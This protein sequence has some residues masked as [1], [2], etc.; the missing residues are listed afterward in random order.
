MNNKL[1]EQ[2]VSVRVKL[3][4]LWTAFMFLYIYVDYFHLYMPGTLNDILSGR[5]FEFDIS[6]AFLIAALVSVSIPAIMIFLS[7]GLKAKV[8]RLANI[9]VASIYIPYTLFNLVGEAWIHMYYGA[10]VEV[11]ILLLVIRYAKKWPTLE[12]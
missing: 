7:V 5:V 6:Q 8:S 12:K 2:K 11:A 1:D 3:A 10:A 9:I 4:A